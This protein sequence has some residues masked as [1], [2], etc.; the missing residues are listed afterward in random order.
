MVSLMGR[1]MTPLVISCVA[2]ELLGLSAVL[3]HLSTVP[4][5]RRGF[6]K[7]WADALSNYILPPY[8]RQLLTGERGTFCLISY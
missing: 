7:K 3:Q 5:I 2:H 6:N 8:L 4:N 1:E